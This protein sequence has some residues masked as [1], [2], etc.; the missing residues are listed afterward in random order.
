MA[1]ELSG[2]SLIGKGQTEVLVSQ[3]VLG[4]TIT[5]QCRHRQWRELLQEKSYRPITML[6]R[7]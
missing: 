5:V 4:V 2:L 6:R 3:G 1:R 7:T